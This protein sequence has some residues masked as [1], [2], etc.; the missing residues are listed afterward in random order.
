LLS[1]QARSRAAH[2]HEPSCGSGTLRAAPQAGQ[3]RSKALLRV[4]PDS[5]A[6]VCASG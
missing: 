1:H 3:L 2:T 5:V 6:Q 4:F